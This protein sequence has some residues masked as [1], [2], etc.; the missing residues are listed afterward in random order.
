MNYTPRRTKDQWQ[1]ILDDYLS[2]GLTVKKY[3]EKN[4]IEYSSFAKWKKRLKP[5]SSASQVS[6]LIKINPPEVNTARVT[7]QTL[8]YTRPKGEALTWD[9]GVDP[10]YIAHILRMI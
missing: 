6:S 7:H 3:C 8:T 5:K 4:N 10:N 1:L 2:S 9:A